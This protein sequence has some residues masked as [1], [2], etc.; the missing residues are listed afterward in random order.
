MLCLKRGFHR[1]L[2][3]FVRDAHRSGY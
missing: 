2:S 1:H 3:E